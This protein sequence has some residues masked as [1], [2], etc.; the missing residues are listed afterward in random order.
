MSL[1]WIPRGNRGAKKFRASDANKKRGQYTQAS[2]RIEWLDARILLDAGVGTLMYPT[3]VINQGPGLDHYQSASPMGYTPAQIRKAYGIDSISINGIVGDGTGQTIAI[4]DAYDWPT[5]VSDLHNFDLQFGLPDPP[6]FTKL[7][8]LGQTSPLPGT[9]PAGA[10]NPKGTWEGEEALDVEWAHAIAPKAN[11]ILVEADS[12]FTSD[13]IDTAVVTAKNL[14]GVSVVSMSFGGGESSV[15]DPTENNIFTTP[16]GHNGVTFLAS[17]GDDGSP[18]GYPAY[19]PNV[20]AVGGTSLFLNGDDSYSSESGWSGSGGGISTFEPKPSYQS[21]LPYNFRSI[22]DVSFIADP[23]T[24]V[25]IYDSYDNGT[26]T[27]WEQIGGTSLSSPAWAGLIAIINQERVEFGDSILD[28]PTQ[29]LPM[30]YN[31]PAGDFHDITSG[32]N[33]DF[34]AAPGYDLV[35]GRGTPI[36]PSLVLDMTPL[37]LRVTPTQIKNATEGIALTNIQVGQFT[38]TNGLQATSTYSGTVDW[39]DGSSPTTVTIVDLKNGTYGILASH[40]YLE[41]GTY[42]LTID[43]AGPNGVVGESSEDVQ[44]QDAPLT[45]ISGFTINTTEGDNFNDLVGSFID[46]NVFALP[47]D[48]TADITWGDGSESSGTVRANGTTAGQFDIFGS[49]IYV[50]AG[51]YNV[52]IAITDVGGSTTVIAGV[53]IVADAALTSKGQTINTTEGSAFSGSVATFSD[54]NSFSSATQFTAIID[55]GDGSTTTPDVTTGVVTSD[56][57]GSYTVSGSHTYAEFGTYTIKIS[58]SDIGT[59]TTDALSTAIIADAKLTGISESLTSNAGQPLVAPGDPAP[60]IGSFKDENPLGKIS[61]FGTTVLVDWGDGTTSTAQITAI[62]NSV[63]DVKADHVYKQAGTFQITIPIKDNGDSSVTVTSTVVVNDAPISPSGFDVSGVEGATIVPEGQAGAV[64]ATFAD[65]NTFQLL[66]DL[67]ATIDW[68]DGTATTPDTSVGIITQPNGLGTTFN[69]LGS[70]IYTFAGTYTITVTITSSGGSQAT[71]TSTATIADA[72]LTGTIATIPAQTEGSTFEGEVATFTDGNP[73]GSVSDFIAPIL[74]GDGNSSIGTITSLGGGKYSIS[75]SNQYVTPGN[76]PIT[77]KVVDIGGS[78]LTLNGT[79]TVLDAPIEPISGTSITLTEG[80]TFSGQVATFHD[81]PTASANSFS[82]TISWGNG[83]SSKG[84]VVSLGQGLFGIQGTEIYQMAGSYPITV[85]ISDDFGKSAKASVT[86][87]V[88]DAAIEATAV[89]NTAV[90]GQAFGGIVANFTDANPYSSAADFVA[91]ITWG[92][93]HVTN[94]QVVGQGNGRFQV[95]GTNTYGTVGSKAVSVSVKDAGGS[96]STAKGAFQVLSPLAGAVNA[97]LVTKD[98]TPI[99]TGSAQPGT[100]IQLFAIPVSTP[101]VRIA[102]G[103]TSVGSTGTWSITS[104]GLSDNIYAI[105]GIMNSSSGTPLQGVNLLQ[106]N[107]LVVDTTGPVVKGVK[108]DPSQGTLSITLH[109]DVSGMN[110]AQMANA[111]N[112]TFQSV[113]RFTQ[114]LPITGIRLVPGAVG[115]GDITEV[116][117]LGMGRPASTYVL[118]INANGLTDRAG[119]TLVEKT[120]VTFPQTTNSP[121]PNYVAEFTVSAGEVSGPE[122]YISLQER[123]AAARYV[124]LSRF[125]FGQNRPLMAQGRFN[126][127]AFRF[128]R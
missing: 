113:G 47:S 34:S 65:L 37:P 101:N 87:K 96:S 31:L 83:D 70:H 38:D 78:N 51:T 15:I 73:F 19:S 114:N 122:Q 92:D 107:A 125:R 104:N 97:P 59:S 67:S 4:V 117:S 26:S 64:V 88:L 56:G 10:G 18:G 82:A 24:G 22:P 20:V 61:D 126:A 3:L 55:W 69:V 84:T 14:P 94:G 9:D 74:W 54:D 112:V 8:Q 52:S 95:I 71:A 90:Q 60:L 7:N 27:P 49:N 98:N 85:T 16:S 35:T 58:I 28:G 80:S 93:G 77:V 23:N 57:N 66:T 86:A 127:R 121:N 109:D 45:P 110:A 36:A 106:S 30:L 1:R 118:T 79:V 48:F 50:L 75:S 102:I 108:F 29:T 99:F 72:P 5:A 46:A 12:A 68:G 81:A 128:L 25:A 91:Q 76:Y 115:S 13:L 105:L 39:G 21:S 41:F 43:V 11:I 119:N 42:T 17:T 120:F 32:N 89:D 116:V 103:G 123:Q 44:V 2:L 111:A 33:G 63:Y 62:G 53:A 124:S 40:T 6:S 100:S